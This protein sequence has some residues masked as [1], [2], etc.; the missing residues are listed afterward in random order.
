MFKNVSV[1]KGL[2]ITQ[3]IKDDME[4]PDSITEVKKDKPAFKVK[5]V[6][7]DEMKFEFTCPRCGSHSSQLVA[8]TNSKYGGAGLSSEKL[9]V[10]RNCKYVETENKNSYS[11]MGSFNAR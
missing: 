3:N 1:K 8:A 11:K 10:C 5:E 6:V 2:N 7:P 9:R 4:K